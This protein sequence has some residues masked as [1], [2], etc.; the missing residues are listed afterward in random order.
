MKKMMKT[1]SYYTLILVVCGALLTACDDFLNI[2]PEGQIKQDELLSTPE[3]IE[4][5]LYGV[6]AQLRTPNLYGQELSFSTIEI[7]AQNLSC[8]GNTTITALADYEYT[9]TGVKGIFE[10]VWTAMYK[11]I[12]NVN[13]ILA[14]PLVSTASAYPYTIYKGESLGLRAFMHFEL[15][16]LYAEQITQ[17]PTADGI[18]Y[19]TEFSLITPDFEPLADNYAHILADLHAAEQLLADEPDHVGDGNF[20]LDRQIHCNLYAVQALLARVYFTK[21]DK[22]KAAEYAAKV[23]NESPY[24]LNV[25]TE[26][27]GDLAGV[28]SQNETL[29]GLYYAEFYTQVYAK[30]QATTSYYSLNPRS[31]VESLYEQK[32]DGLDYRTAAYFSSV[33]LG[34]QPTLRLSKLTDVYELQGIPASRPK[35]LIQGVNL[36]RLPEM[37]YIM[38]E[39]ML[40][41][42]QDSAAWYFDQVLVS[43]GLT[44]L[45]ER[46]PADTLSIELINLERF[47]EYFGEGQHFYNLKRQHLS[48]HA[49]DVATGKEV[50]IP[51]SADVFVAPI[52]DSEYENRY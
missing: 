52:P 49:V 21:G 7:L 16:R 51:A 47:K 20:M 24:R 6:Y 34:G 45:A 12:S 23:I 31:D 5:A 27:N 13:S 22:A 18:P 1:S 48:I 10:S 32:A 37:Y 19:A 40:E 2:T 42:E 28:L 26:I 41:E 46:I 9:H 50:V 44:P 17:N 43:R 39:V 35:E 15:V 4:D 33:E 3:G 14:S 36:I 8:K 29:F 11:N 25:K 30:L 38:A